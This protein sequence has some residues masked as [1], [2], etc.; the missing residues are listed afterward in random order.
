MKCTAA[1]I[2]LLFGIGWAVDTVNP[3]YAVGKAG[4][5]LLPMVAV[6]AEVKWPRRKRWDGKVPAPDGGQGLSNSGQAVSAPTWYRCEQDGRTYIIDPNPPP[7]PAGGSAD[8][9]D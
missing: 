4:L 5:A 9:G 8:G 6:L 7:V 1:L 3:W 2:I